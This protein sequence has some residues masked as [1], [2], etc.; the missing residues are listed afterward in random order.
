[1]KNVIRSVALCGVAA[2]MLV[3]TACNTTKGF[4]E[5]LDAVGENISDEADDNGAR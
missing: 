2:L 4:G 1:M 5:D 3:M